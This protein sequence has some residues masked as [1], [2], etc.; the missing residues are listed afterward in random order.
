MDN[1]A[2]VT[3][4]PVVGQYGITYKKEVDELPA[5]GWVIGKWFESW[6]E[7]MDYIRQMEDLEFDDDEGGKLV[8]SSINPILAEHWPPAQAEPYREAFRAVLQWCY[9]DREKLRHEIETLRYQKTQVLAALHQSELKVESVHER[10]KSMVCEGDV[11][12]AVWERQQ[13]L[14]EAVAAIYAT[15]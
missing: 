10:Y 12:D 3:W 15:A 5:D 9:A 2:V 1:K 11:R 6:K 13:N 7:A 8:W 4:H 14:F